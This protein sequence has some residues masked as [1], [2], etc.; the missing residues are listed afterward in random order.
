MKNPR[1]LNS[2]V[3]RLESLS[4]HSIVYFLGKV[5]PG[6]ISLLSIFFFT[7]KLGFADYGI[8]SLSLPLIIFLNIVFFQWLP[9]SISKFYYS[10]SVSKLKLRNL[11]LII[12]NKIA[13]LF[14]T[15]SLL[16]YF[17]FVPKNFKSIF[18]VSVFFLLSLAWY[19]LH[20]QFLQIKLKSF[21]YSFFDSFRSI[22]ALSFCFLCLFFIQSPISILFGTGLGYLITAYLIYEYSKKLHFENGNTRLEKSFLSLFNFGFPYALS[23][24]IIHFGNFAVRL[25]L[26]INYGYEIVGQYSPSYD[27]VQFVTNFLMSAITMAS[28]PILYKSFGEGKI[29]FA[30][31]SLLENFILQILLGL[32]LMIG[33]I[34]LA[35]DFSSLFFKGDYQKIS[36]DLI[37]AFS[38]ASF[39][40]AIRVNYFDLAFHI[41]GHTFLIF[42]ITLTSILIN[43]F[44][45]FYFFPLYGIQGI[46]YALI[47][48][49]VCSLVMSILIGR[50]FYPLQLFT[51]DFYKAI[52][53]L[54]FVSLIFS[55]QFKFLDLSTLY[56][57]IF[58]IFFGV[59]VYFLFL[60]LMKFANIKKINFKKLL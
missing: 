19:D 23:L 36:E 30:R 46:A 2:T 59:T 20:I 35:K 34:I 3:S 14:S 6:I 56:T 41:S 7:R 50:Y 12:F 32:P 60:Y 1:L 29:N 5:I 54:F 4:F 11:S 38:I 39:I 8:L 52:P 43:I 44:C 58:K 49:S 45:L 55:M 57:L 13:L 16:I 28:L 15:L 37:P 42:F 9:I 33:F 31:K 18:L 26:T 51:K 17:F 10:R 24:G 40:I 21:F 22:I 53:S 27:L 47:I 48:M 25:F